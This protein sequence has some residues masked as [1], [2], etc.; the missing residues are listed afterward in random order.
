MSQARELSRVVNQL[1]AISTMYDVNLHDISDIRELA[2]R[3]G[4]TELYN[5]LV[6]NPT[7]Y[8]YEVLNRYE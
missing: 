5:M 4:Y 6:E 3:E 7:K 8:F 2:L 1:S